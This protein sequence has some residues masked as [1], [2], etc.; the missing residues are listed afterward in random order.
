[1]R[2]F[3]SGDFLYKTN[4]SFHGIWANLIFIS[5]EIRKNMNTT[6]AQFRLRHK[7]KKLVLYLHHINSIK[8]ISPERTQSAAIVFMTGKAWSHLRCAYVI[9]IQFHSFTFQLQWTSS[10]T[11]QRK[12]YT[13]TLTSVKKTIYHVCTPYKMFDDSNTTMCK[14]IY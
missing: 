10:R 7:R 12:L 5:T 14:S 11:M 2:N 9:A 13:H 3:S 6:R 8:S 1:M 4:A